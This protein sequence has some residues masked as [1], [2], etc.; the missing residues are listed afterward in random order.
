MTSTDIELAEGVPDP[1]WRRILS[2]PERAPELIAVAASQR[3]AAPAERWVQIA[4]AGHSPESLADTAFKKHVRLS[5]VEG[6]ALGLGGV[7]TGAANLA[8]LLWIQARMVF[9]IAAAH[10]YDPSHPMRPAELLALWEVYESPAA[11]RAAL[12]GMGTP[13]AKAVLESKLNAGDQRN[14]SQ[15]LVRHVG[16][17]VAKRYA[18]RMIPLLGAPISSVQNGGVTKSLGARALTYYGGADAARDE[19][20]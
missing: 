15:K 16:K 12:D 1:V 17:R 9:F 2:E 10:G 6:L 8:G 11:A 13:M 7:V 19:R 18:G 20:L 3:F 14:L 4:G 5:R